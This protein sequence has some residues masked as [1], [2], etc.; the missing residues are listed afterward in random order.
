MAS[1]TLEGVVA[2]VKLWQHVVLDSLSQSMLGVNRSR[3]PEFPV[4]VHQ[5]SVESA[6]PGVIDF[7]NRYMIPTAGLS[8]RFCTR[9][10][11]RVLCGSSA[12]TFK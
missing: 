9:V 7:A 3:F 11:L 5:V 8:M 12:M 6:T 1:P 10:A 4:T 2:I